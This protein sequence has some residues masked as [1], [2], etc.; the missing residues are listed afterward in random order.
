M[1]TKITNRWALVFEDAA[2][3]SMTVGISQ[4]D[5]ETEDAQVKAMMAAFI[6]NGQIFASV[7][8]VKVSA[9]LVTTTSTSYDVE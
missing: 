4:A 8:T 2:G 6:T 5:D 7:P 1:A 3:K 9:T